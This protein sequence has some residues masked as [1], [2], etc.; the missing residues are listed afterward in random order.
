MNRTP[1]QRPAFTLIELLV[2][3]AIIAILIALL[4]PAVQQAREAAR[5]TQC[6]NNLKQIGLGLHNYLDSFMVF[7]PG[8]IYNPNSGSPWMGWSW[9]TMLLPQFDQAPLYNQMSQS[10]NPSINGGMPTAAWV[11]TQ[12]VLNALRCP[13]DVGSLVVP[14]VY[15]SGV[16][17]GNAAP[18]TLTASVNNYG[19]SNYFGV[20]GYNGTSPAAVNGGLTLNTPPLVGTFRG[21]FGENSR[22]GLRDMTDGSTNVAMV[23]ERYTPAPNP[24]AAADDAAVGHGAWAG[25]GGRGATGGLLGVAIS[26]GTQG[27]VF[28]QAM[29]LGDAAGTNITPVAV[30]TTA[31]G[32]VAWYRINGNNTGAAP[33]GPTT[34]FGSM[35]TGGCHFLLGDGSVRFVNDNV[36]VVL[37]RNLSTI[38]DGAVLGDF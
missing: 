9:M 16:N 14:T 37:Y 7:P 33:R 30:P 19:R 10:T 2:V 22:V 3:I 15:I 5:R 4:L 32:A 6:K 35:H 29:V 1:R 8:Y 24:A 27:G 11:Q 34:G 28:A 20:A 18:G 36:D 13:S 17:S 26:A 31:Q 25:A 21:S 23:G 12:S 38:S